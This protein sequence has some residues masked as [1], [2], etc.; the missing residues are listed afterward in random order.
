MINRTH[1]L[2]NNDLLMVIT[3]KNGGTV[4]MLMFTH[5]TCT[6]ARGKMDLLLNLYIFN[7]KERK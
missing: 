6:H 4:H 3:V 7:H 1:I 5:T 2:Y